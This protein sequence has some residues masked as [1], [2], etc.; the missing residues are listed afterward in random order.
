M[1]RLYYLDSA[2]EVQGPV[3]SDQ[4]Q[5]LYRSGGITEGTQVCVEG[6]ENWQP[7]YQSQVAQIEQ[8]KR[9]QLF[10]STTK[11]NAETTKREMNSKDKP[12]ITKAQGATLIILLLIGIGASFWVFLKPTPKW[13]YRTLEVLAETNDTALTANEKNIPIRLC[14]M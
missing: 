1:I 5:S 8:P 10:S 11:T 9:S 14:P 4:L 7:Y 12:G 13:E 3:T 2:G 6:G